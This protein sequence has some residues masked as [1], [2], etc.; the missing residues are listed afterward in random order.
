MRL[1]EPRLV[2]HLAAAYVLGTLHGGARRRFERALRERVD[3]RLAV[4]GWQ[5]RLG[6]LGC[7]LQPVRPSPRVWA[8]I[9]ARTQ[10]EGADTHRAGSPRATG[11][12]WPGGWA[13][14][15][16]AIAGLAS[17]LALMLAL[18][19]AAPALLVTPD[20][21]AMAAGERLPQSYVGV[22]TDAD[23]RGRLLVS[24][25]RHGHQAT[26]KVLG[27][28]LALP[29]G[30]TAVLWA[31]PDGSPP[32]R[33]ATVPREGQAQA[34]MPDTAERLLSRVTRL[35]VTAEA[36]AGATAP[37]GPVLVSGACAKL[38]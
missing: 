1:A 38:W 19:F 29:E 24:S 22:L 23:G 31:L 7:A 13:R 5:Q 4:Q 14:V 10:A 34:R 11:S 9:A 26:L 25:L 35:A 36:D 30:R 20:R 17:G 12:S 6:L 27:G 28:P 3:L 18:L 33:L 8:G 16:W 21:A 32:V 15:G 2:D 37:T